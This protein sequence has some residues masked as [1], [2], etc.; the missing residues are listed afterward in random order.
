MCKIGKDFVD[1]FQ[2]INKKKFKKNDKTLVKSLF[3]V[4]FLNSDI[5]EVT[6]D[7]KIVSNTYNNID[8]GTGT[9]ITAASLF[10]ISDSKLKL[11]Q[12][13]DMKTIGG[14]RHQIQLTTKQGCTVLSRIIILPN[15]SSASQAEID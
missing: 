3:N 12:D 6:G 15:E 5:D 8:D 11:K 10:E 9:S 14:P 4:S 13:V 2:K 1:F 7:I